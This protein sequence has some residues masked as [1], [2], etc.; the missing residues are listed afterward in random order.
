MIRLLGGVNGYAPRGL[1]F[2]YQTTFKGERFSYL[3]CS[4]CRTVFVDP[5]PSSEAFRA[6]YE[7][8][9]YH[10]VHYDSVGDAGYRESVALLA[11]YAQTGAVVLD[12]GCGTGEFIKASNRAGFRTV[13][14]DFDGDVAKLAGERTGFAF[15]FAR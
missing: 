9:H 14:V 4:D 3:A 10:D 15:V 8:A 12:Y 7:K 13:G 1:E 6:M 5:V 2:P 11:T